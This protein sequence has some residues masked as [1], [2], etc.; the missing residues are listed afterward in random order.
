MTYSSIPAALTA[1]AA[2]VDRVAGEV[3]QRSDPG[4]AVV[5]LRRAV[6]LED[7]PLLD[8]RPSVGLHVGERLLQRG[9]QVG[10]DLR[11]VEAADG[12]DD[13][14]RRDRV[15]V[16]VDVRHVVGHGR[17][18]VVHAG[19][20][21]RDPLVDVV[22]VVGVGLARHGVQGDELRGPAGG[23]RHVRRVGRPRAGVG[24]GRLG[25]GPDGERGTAG[26]AAV[27]DVAAFGEGAAARHRERRGERGVGVPRVGREDADEGRV[28][29]VGRDRRR[30][31]GVVGVPVSSL[32]ST[33]GSTVS[34]PV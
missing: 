17:R 28:A 34:T 9:G 15:V 33:I 19:E 18:V 31:D 27:R 14:R 2:A 26:R 29:V 11:D 1:F 7:D 21:D 25:A 4:L 5:V 3:A 16:G 8:V 10:A 30:G 20:P 24:A 13:V 22:D 6:G 23:E 32:A 12:L